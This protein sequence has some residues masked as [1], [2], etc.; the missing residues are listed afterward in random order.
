MP[1]TSR[2]ADREY[3]ASANGRKLRSGVLVPTKTE[4]TLLFAIVPLLI[5]G[6]IFSQ[7]IVPLSENAYS[8]WL[9]AWGIATFV[10]YGMD[11]LLAR[12]GWWRVPEILLHVLAVV[13]GFAGGWLGMLIFWHKVRKTSFWVVLFVSTLIHGAAVYWLYMR[14]GSILG[15]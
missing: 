11:K 12:L 10:T 4:T 8:V 6:F 7:A 14:G 9:V 3:A 2:R 1:N 5:V 15:L 13:G